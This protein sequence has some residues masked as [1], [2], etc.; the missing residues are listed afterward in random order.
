MCVHN[1]MLGVWRLYLLLCL[2]WII[3]EIVS[4]EKPA[5]NCIH[6]IVGDKISI[7]LQ[8]HAFLESCP[9]GFLTWLC[10]ELA[11]NSRLRLSG[12][13]CYQYIDDVS[14]KITTMYNL[15]YKIM[16]FCNALLCYGPISCVWFIH[17]VDLLILVSIA[18]L[19]LLQYHFYQCHLSQP[20]GSG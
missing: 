4:D 5:L 8:L 12:G 19:T 20:F 17:A 13:S 11:L 9:S 10:A 7:M 2:R 15:F 6:P 16:W 3:F 14:S 18:S 1:A